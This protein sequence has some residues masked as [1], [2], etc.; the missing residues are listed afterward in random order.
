MS[1]DISIKA[2]SGKNNPEFQKHYKAVQ[3]CVEN[4][5]SYPKETSEFFRGKIDGDDLEDYEIDYI[6]DYIKDGIEVP[7]KFEEN[8]ADV[9]GYV[10][11]I[12]VSDIPK[13]V[14]EIVV[15]LE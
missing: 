10:Y 5:L 4:D 3:F 14:D 15:K 2:Y 9:Y 11:R 7:L 12:K 6:E 8:E 13:E 1:V